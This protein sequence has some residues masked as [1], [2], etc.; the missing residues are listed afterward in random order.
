MSITFGYIEKYKSLR[1]LTKK[2]KLEIKQP[3][4]IKENSALVDTKSRSIFNCLRSL[5]IMVT[6]T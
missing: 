3:F 1:C 2:R 4:K 5:Y 6:N